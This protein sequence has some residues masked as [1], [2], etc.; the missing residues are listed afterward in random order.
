MRAVV[1]FESLFGNTEQVA[2]A[3]GDG[4]A[5]NVD[6]DVVEVQA[7]PHDLPGVDLVVAGG[8]THAF[9]MTRPR[10]REDAARQSSQAPA[11]QGIGLRE[12]IDGLPDAA[13]PWVTATFDTRV[14]RVRRLPGSAAKGAAKALRARGHR[15]VAA[16][17]SFYV[18]DVAGP[19]VAGELERARAWGAT[20]GTLLGPVGAVAST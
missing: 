12:W 7:A 14:T 4:L 18:D 5:G 16:P 2:R 20:L 19:L 17:E 13:A 8:P 1:V 6:V 11:P 15:T 3:I 10:T 9:G